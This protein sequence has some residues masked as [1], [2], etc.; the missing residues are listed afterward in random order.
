MKSMKATSTDGRPLLVFAH[1]G[2]AQAFLTHFKAGPI[3]LP[4]L[5]RVNLFESSECLILLTGE[6]KVEAHNK[7]K[8]VFPSLKQINFIINLGVAG[9]LSPKLPLGSVALIQKIFALE[10]RSYECALT[11]TQGNWIAADLVTAEKRI[12]DAKEALPLAQI[13]PLVD[14]EAHGLAQAALALH[15]PFI[16]LKVV[17]DLPW[18]NAGQDDVRK[19]AA[20]WST[21]LLQAFQQ[22][23]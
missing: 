15:L 6:G 13:A 2:E 21:L 11:R 22:L 19:K 17:S 3:R 16:S 5:E 8:S 20:E 9:A 12:L 7:L 18:K 14:R 23:F 4:S 1:K 10:E